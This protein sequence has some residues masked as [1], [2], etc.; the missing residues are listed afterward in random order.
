MSEENN[1]DDLMKWVDNVLSWAKRAR[2]KEEQDPHYKPRD[3]LDMYLSKQ[4]AEEQMIGIEIWK[5]HVR[6]QS[7]YQL[8]VWLNLEKAMQELK[9][10]QIILEEI[11]LREK[12]K[13]DT[14]NSTQQII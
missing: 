3:K 7:M 13:D 14:Q 2:E 5:R 4:S 8:K 10:C 6:T 9:I 12:L 11:E 1:D